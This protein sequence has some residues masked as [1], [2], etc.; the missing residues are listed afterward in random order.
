MKLI[1]M[2]N[3]VRKTIKEMD[4]LSINCNTFENDILQYFE[5]AGYTVKNGTEGLQILKNNAWYPF[6]IDLIR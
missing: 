3:V 6:N 4:Y 1:Y 2:N 5:E